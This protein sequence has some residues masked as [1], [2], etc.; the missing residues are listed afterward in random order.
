MRGKESTKRGPTVTSQLKCTVQMCQH[1]LSLL[2]V[3]FHTVLHTLHTLVFTL[4][5]R[6]NVCSLIDKQLQKVQPDPVQGRINVVCVC[7]VV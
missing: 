7:W 2:T 4:P 6:E 5:E 3:V 1:V